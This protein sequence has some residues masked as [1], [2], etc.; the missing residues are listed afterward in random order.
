MKAIWRTSNQIPFLERA[1]TSGSQNLGLVLV[2]CDDVRRTA[3]LSFQ[4]AGRKV[5][6]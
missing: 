5:R 2:K 1:D 3:L 4:E 6:A